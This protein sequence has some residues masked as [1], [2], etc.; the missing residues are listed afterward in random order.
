MPRA[1]LPFMIAFLLVGC[2]KSTPPPTPEAVVQPTASPKTSAPARCAPASP[3]PPFVLG[4]KDTGR[5]ANARVD[6]GEPGRDDIMPFAAE[7][8]DGVA[9]Q[10]GFAVGAIHESET[11]LAMSVVTLDA[12]GHNAKIIPLGIAHGDVEPPRLF[13]TGATLAAG[14][15]EPAANGRTLRLAKITNG[16]VAWGATLHEQGG[17]SQAFDIALG[18][19]KGIVVWDEDGPA[20]SIVQ[21]STFDASTLANAT[22]PRTISRQTADAES[23]RLIT[24]AAGGYWLAY[25]ARSAAPFS[26]D[27]SFV[28]DE[29]GFR[30]VEVVALDANGSPTGVARAATPKD[31]HV[32][33]F[34]LAPAPDGGALVVY[35]N[36]DTPTGA[37][38]GE[39]MRVLVHPAS[40]DAP[41]VLVRDEVGAGVPNVLPGWIAVLDAADVTRLAP[42]GPLGEIAAPLN[43]EPDIGSGEPI[44]GNSNNL[45][46]ARPSGRAVTLVVLRCRPDVLPAD[47]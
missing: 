5:A 46:V 4:P 42:L 38:G 12:D 24:R 36:D 17:E 27:A 34:D 18:E 21:V 2:K 45:L 39:V 37:A 41:S 30:W 13:A 7:V 20:S 8:G 15:L 10:G 22:P 16:E 25:V 19:K 40:I 33:V 44:A 32:M 26:L 3:D 9:W 47:P 6:A 23:P 43:P 35:R 1:A 11:S 31:G 29:I 28:A 14:I